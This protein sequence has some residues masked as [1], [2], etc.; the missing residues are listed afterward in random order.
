MSSSRGRLQLRCAQAPGSAI[1]VAEIKRLEAARIALQKEL[2]GHVEAHEGWN[3]A[4]A[5][6]PKDEWR[7]QA[8]QERREH[9]EKVWNEHTELQAR[10]QRIQF[11]EDQVVEQNVF[12]AVGAG[13]NRFRLRWAS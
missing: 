11:A 6:I 10:I 4:W 3:R 5:L 7:S 2:Q 1:S 8:A 12:A 13:P 9:T